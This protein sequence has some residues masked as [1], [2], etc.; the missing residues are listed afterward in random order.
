MPLRIYAPRPLVFAANCTLQHDR[1]AL[2]RPFT[3]LNMRAQGTYLHAEKCVRNYNRKGSEQQQAMPGIAS[4]AGSYQDWLIA[5][6][7]SR[8]NAHPTQTPGDHWM[9]G[10]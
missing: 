3:T 6:G 4:I 7:H 1:H 5:R 9:A 10:R 2:T 8:I